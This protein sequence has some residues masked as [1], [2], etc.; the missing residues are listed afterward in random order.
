MIQ[1]NDNAFMEIKLDFRSRVPLSE[2]VQGAVRQLI[3][4]NVLQPGDPLPTVRGLASWLNVNFNTVARAYR[5]LDMEGW[6]YTHQ[7]R[8]TQVAEHEEIQRDQIQAARGIYLKSLVD[9]V[10]ATANQAGISVIEL[11]AEINRRLQASQK[12]KM[13]KYAPRTA[14]FTRRPLHSRTRTGDR[15]EIPEPQNQHQAR[16]NKPLKKSRNR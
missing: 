5:V 1:T 11:R 9:Q 3:L 12:R 14:A 15:P 10:L 8:G 16:K 2:Q 13:R 6:I 7:G 4:R